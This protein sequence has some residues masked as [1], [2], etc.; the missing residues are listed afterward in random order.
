MLNLNR[1]N[2]IHPSLPLFFC[3]RLLFPMYLVFIMPEEE[4]IASRKM[5]KHVVDFLHGW[6]LIKITSNSDNHRSCPFHSYI[7]GHVHCFIL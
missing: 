2:F 5:N 6:N 1:G 3:K 4:Q 7:N